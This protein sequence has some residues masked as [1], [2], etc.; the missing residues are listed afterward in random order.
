MGETWAIGRNT[1]GEVCVRDRYGKTDSLSSAVKSIAV[2][3]SHVKS[4]DLPD[5]QLL[6]LYARHH[7]DVAFATLVRR[8]APMVLG[9]CRR[10]VGHQQEAEDVCQATFFVLASRAASIHKTTSVRS[11]LFGTACRLSLRARRDA[12]RRRRREVDRYR[13]DR[14]DAM[15]EQALR[16]LSVAMAEELVRLPES[17]R[18]AIVLCYYEGKTH[19]EAAAEL[20]LS[21]ATLRR[22]RD[23]ALA[24]LRARL[25]RRGLAL[26]AGLLALLIEPTHASAGLPPGTVSAIV[27]AANAFVKGPIDLGGLASANSMALARGGL[28]DIMCTKLKM[29]V[30][31]VMATGIAG[32]GLGALSSVGHERSPQ[33]SPPAV[34][35]IDNKDGSAKSDSDLPLGHRDD[36]PDGCTARLGSGAWNSK[37]SFYAMTFA[38]DGKSLACMQMDGVIRKHSPNGR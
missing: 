19:D 18:A 8:H 29:I 12:Q 24:L 21:N 6:G 33:Q 13:G 17:Y 22:H 20:G 36:L 15:A 32:L 9:T 2:S 37:S 3:L 14:G 30:A 7:D 5:A 16:E 31:L 34:A 28:R 11:W 1:N 4:A 35:L 25:L 26:S 27:K 10:L 23:R 38:P